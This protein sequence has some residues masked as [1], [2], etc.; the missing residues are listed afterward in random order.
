M[1][2]ET[3]LATSMGALASLAALIVNGENLQKD[4]R[5]LKTELFGHVTVVTQ[6][7]VVGLMLGIC[8]GVLTV[9]EI[10]EAVS[11]AN[12][13]N[14]NERVP[15]EQAG[16][17][18]RIIGSI[19]PSGP[20]ANTVVSFSGDHG[21]PKMSFNTRWTFRQPEGWNFFVFNNTGTAI[22]TGGLVHVHATHYGV[23]V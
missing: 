15:I 22:T 12:P 14:P 19:K 17:M 11:S 4:F 10:A 8:N 7:D 6:A 18:V 13:D 23:W 2:R 1:I 20:D 3:E 16:R 21:G 5:I 9:G